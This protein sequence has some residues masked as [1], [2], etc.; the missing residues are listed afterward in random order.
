MEDAGTRVPLI[1]NWPD[2]TP[3]GEVCEDLIDFSDFMPTLAEIAGA[4]LPQGVTIDGQSFVNQIRGRNGNE[5]TWAF[6]Y[7]RSEGSGWVRTPRYKLYFNGELYDVVKDPLE[8]P[9]GLILEKY[10]TPE[11]AAVRKKLQR[12]ID[13]FPV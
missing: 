11:S 10:D 7:W 2:T 4:G 8:S 5:R 12:V 3:A 1:V 13:S 9:A 6:N